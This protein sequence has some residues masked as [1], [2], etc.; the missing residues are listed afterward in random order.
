MPRRSPTSTRKPGARLGAA[1]FLEAAR[2]W[3]APVV[4]EALRAHPE[5]ASV[6]DRTGRTALHLCAA[7]T[8][9]RTPR[10]AAA[11]VAT[12]RELLKAGAKLD[13]V[14]AIPDALEAF[15][16]TPLWH[17]VARGKNRALARFLLKEGAGPDYCLWAVVWSDDVVMARLL[18]AHGANLDLTFH[19]ETP[20]LYATRL[21]RTRMLKWL[22]RHGAN[23]NIGD[24]EGRTPLSY[25]VRRRYALAEVEELLRHGADVSSPAKDGSSPLSLLATGRDTRLAQLVR[26]YGRT[27]ATAGAPG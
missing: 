10:P 23:P 9:A 27:P 1:R 15:P 3:D 6:T 5:L 8:A 20:L 13:A 4:A 21:R 17:A 26:K 12:A 22:L 24:R 25:A 11:S 16:A 14:H 18:H 2:R 7:A 19:G